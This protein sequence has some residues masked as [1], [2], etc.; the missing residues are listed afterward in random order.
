MA[1]N[2]NKEP[3]QSKIAVIDKPQKNMNTPKVLHKNVLG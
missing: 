3:A 1:L 2:K